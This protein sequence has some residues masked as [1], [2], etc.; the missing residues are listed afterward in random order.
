LNT[1]EGNGLDLSLDFPKNQ[2]ASLLETI[3]E[4]LSRIINRVTRKGLI[5]LEGSRICIQDLAGLEDIVRG[6]RKL[7]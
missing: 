1:I 4:M 5:R 2:L 3:P 7:V 6:G